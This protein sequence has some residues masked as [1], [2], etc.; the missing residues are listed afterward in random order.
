M[1]ADYIYG[2]FYE[3]LRK[4][5]SFSPYLYVGYRKNSPKV[6]ADAPLS[7]L[8]YLWGERLETELT[9]E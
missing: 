1:V 7:R 8:G 9:V 4:R 5:F 6:L 3:F 2:H